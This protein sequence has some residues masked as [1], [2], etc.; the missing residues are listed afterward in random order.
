MTGI[1][2]SAAISIANDGSSKIALAA[3]ANSGSMTRIFYNQ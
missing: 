3:G 1:G 2:N